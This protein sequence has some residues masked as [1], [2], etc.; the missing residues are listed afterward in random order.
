MERSDN[1]SSDS[2]ERCEVSR[3]TL[4]I[5]HGWLEFARDCWKDRKDACAPE[6][7]NG[8]E[9][10]IAEIRKVLWEEVNKE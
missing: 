2:E 8:I 9:S 7:R 10:A 6:Y 3:I 1:L 5:A 4:R